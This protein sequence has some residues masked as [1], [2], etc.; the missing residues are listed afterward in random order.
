MSDITY[1]LKFFPDFESK[2]KVIEFLASKGRTDLVD[3]FDDL[4]IDDAGS[5]EV[6][7][8]LMQSKCLPFSLYSLEKDD[9]RLLHD[10]IKILFPKLKLELKEYSSIVW[11]EAWEESYNSYETNYFFIS[12][13]SESN[14]SSKIQIKMDPGKAF[15]SGQH[16]TTKVCLEHLEKFHELDSSKGKSFLDVGTG[17]G[18]LCLAAHYFSYSHIVGTDIDEDSWDSVDVNKA[19]NKIDFELIKGSLPASNREY[20]LVVSNI[21]PPTVTNLIP[22]FKSLLSRDGMLFLSGFNESNEDVVVRALEKNGFRVEDRN[23]LRGWLSLMA[24][25]KK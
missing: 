19:L 17:T 6:I 1:E 9:L 20:D 11:N 12:P 25:M 16:A 21:L 14:P 2:E 4:D 23:S 10:E 13:S 8:E 5:S 3:C 15:G 24:K 18:V 7:E 22:D